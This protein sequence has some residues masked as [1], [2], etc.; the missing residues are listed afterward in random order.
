MTSL[1]SGGQ[2]PL[3]RIKAADTAMADDVSRGHRQELGAISVLVADGVPEPRHEEEECGV[4]KPNGCAV[5]VRGSGREHCQQ[6][7]DAH[8]DKDDVSRPTVLAAVELD[9]Q[10]AVDPG[11]PDQAE[12]DG[13]LDGTRTDVCSAS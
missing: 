12:D 5:A 1:G 11:E 13:E 10:R 7:E 6:R 3:T 9:V 4:D 2:K 8:L